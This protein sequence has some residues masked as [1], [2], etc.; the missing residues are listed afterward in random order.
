MMG[1]FMLAKVH[2]FVLQGIHATRCEVEV[3]L[4]MRVYG[5]KP[6]IVGLADAAV[7]ESMDRIRSAMANSA[8]AFPEQKLLVNLAPADLRKEGSALELPITLGILYVSKCITT[9]RHRKFLVAGEVALDGR[10]R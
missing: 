5:E 2:A 3:D 1:L 6:L 7:R 4:A 10:V 9:E 8:Y